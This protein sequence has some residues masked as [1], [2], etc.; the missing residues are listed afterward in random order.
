MSPTKNLSPPPF[1]VS[2]ISRQHSVCARL[3]ACVRACVL[4]TPSPTKYPSPPLFSVSSVSRHPRTRGSVCVS[5]CVFRIRC[6]RTGAFSWR[7]SYSHHVAQC[8]RSAANDCQWC[9]PTSPPKVAVIC[10]QCVTF[11]KSHSNSK[12]RPV[13]WWKVTGHLLTHTHTPARVH[14]RGSITNSPGED[15]H[16]KQFQD[17]SNLICNPAWLR[18]TLTQ[19][20]AQCHPHAYLITHTHLFGV[21]SEE[22]RNQTLPPCCHLNHLTRTHSS[23][24]R[25]HT[26][27][28]THLFLWIRSEELIHLQRVGNF[29]YGPHHLVRSQSV[30]LRVT[31]QTCNH[32]H[33]G[34]LCIRGIR[35]VKGTSVPLNPTLNGPR[36]SPL[37]NCPTLKQEKQC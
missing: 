15:L 2:S 10:A 29:L 32:I 14:V 8:A 19:S 25:T 30:Q 27:S 3:C 24:A 18:H 16:T 21:H 22:L 7:P 34:L 4:L 17:R 9:S 33:P 5:N 11:S 20:H 37:C 35:V 26:C 23:H 6:R 12:E 31:V 36:V 13:F 1:S 28:H